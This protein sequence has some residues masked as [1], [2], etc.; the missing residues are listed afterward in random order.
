MGEVSLGEHSEVAPPLEALDYWPEPA[1]VDAWCESLVDRVAAEPVD[2]VW[3]KETVQTGPASR[4]FGPCWVQLQRG[5]RRFYAIWQPAATRGPGPLLIH[6]PGYG[7]EASV[8]PELV[9]DGFNVLHVNPCGY[10]GPSGPDATKM[11]GGKQWPVLPD[12]A[13]SK[14]R[15]GYVD[16]LGDALAAVG[17]ARGLE[18]VQ[19][20]RVATFGTSQGGGGALL[21]ASLLAGDCRAVCADVPF[22]TAFPV[23]LEQLDD[24]GVYGMIWSRWHDT[25]GDEQVA[26][27]RAVCMIDTCA[28]VHRLKMPVLLTLGQRDK[29]CPA[30]TIRTLFG[31]LGATRSLTEIADQGHAHTVEFLALARAWMALHV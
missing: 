21:M 1:E 15:I 10:H 8:H 28:H 26:T 12:T 11:R 3:M 22:V 9:A 14:G 19:A 23:A 4:H 18:S 17:W 31:R 2:A 13:T 16:W 27:R 5:P 29:A 30:P 6:L 7:A 20:N 25:R 24:P